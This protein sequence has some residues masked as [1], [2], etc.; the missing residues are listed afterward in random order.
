MPDK[1]V[2]VEKSIFDEREWEAR[3]DQVGLDLEKV[4]SREGL[5][6]A[7]LFGGLLIVSSTMTYDAFTDGKTDLKLAFLLLFFCFMWATVFWWSIQKYFAAHF[8]LSGGSKVLAF[9]INSPNEKT[10]RQFI[11]K[12]REKKK[13]KLRET[14]GFDPDLTF[15]EQLDQLRYLKRIEVLTQDEFES[16]REELRERHLL[17]R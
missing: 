9:F 14:T 13:E 7:I 2:V 11:D 16:I 15:E 4:K 12:I 6:N 3:Y 17:K 5:G 8:I 1:L 10:V